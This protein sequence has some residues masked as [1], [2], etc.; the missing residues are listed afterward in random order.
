MEKHQ[1]SFFNTAENST[2]LENSDQNSSLEEILKNIDE[3]SKFADNS[4]SSV[5]ENL[6]TTRFVHH[7]DLSK[8]LNNSSEK[9]ISSNESFNLY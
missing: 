6:K 3:F 5:R 2:L 4:I 7:L 1:D 9:N 8:I